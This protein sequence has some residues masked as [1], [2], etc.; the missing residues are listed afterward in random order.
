MHNQSMAMQEVGKKTGKKRGQKGPRGLPGKLGD[1]GDS[2]YCDPLTCKKNTLKMMV[3]NEYKN[4]SETRL[5]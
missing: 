1:R 2:G 4:F 3:I 5:S